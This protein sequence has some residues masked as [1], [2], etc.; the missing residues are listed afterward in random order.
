MAEHEQWVFVGGRVR[1]ARLAA[2]MTVRDL[3]RRI[4]VSASHV[5]QVERG[6]GA[7]SV[8]ALYA[9][10]REMKVAMMRTAGLLVARTL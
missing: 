9:V 5:S 3:A 4:G 7:F 10:A 6:I 1:D 2:G 8:P